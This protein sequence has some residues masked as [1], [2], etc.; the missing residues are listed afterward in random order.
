MRMGVLPDLLT[1]MVFGWLVGWILTYLLVGLGVED[2][3]E[4]DP[5]LLSDW[6]LGIPGGWV[7]LP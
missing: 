7:C 4:F 2:E 5:E 1:V 6:V 3:E